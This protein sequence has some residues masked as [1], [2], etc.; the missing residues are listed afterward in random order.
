MEF[1][2]DTPEEILANL[3]A[4]IA[5]FEDLST[6]STKYQAKVQGMR[7]SKSRLEKYFKGE[8][9]LK[10]LPWEDKERLTFI[11]SNFLGT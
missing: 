10:E 1:T 11:P 3:D 5:M 2:K 9:T 4:N 6:I 8:L 7:E